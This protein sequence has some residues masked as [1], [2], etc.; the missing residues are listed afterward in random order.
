MSTKWGL[1]RQTKEKIPKGKYYINA[2]KVIDN[3][4]FKKMVTEINVPASGF[5]IRNIILE[6]S[7]FVPQ[8]GFNLSVQ[9]SIGG[10]IPMA[11][12]YLYS[13]QVLA[14]ANSTNGLFGNFTTD[15]VGK[16]S[17]YDLPT[18][19]YYLNVSKFISDTLIYESLLNKITVPA[20][21]VI[22][23]TVVLRRKR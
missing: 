3:V 14:T 5:V 15:S 6:R 7:V 21:D 9:D 11:R 12:V 19:D 10:I 17:R 22:S 2:K 8:N 16:L 23:Q 13:S 1:K 20:S 18:G 4:T